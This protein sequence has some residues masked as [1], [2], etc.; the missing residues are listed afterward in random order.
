[1]HNKRYFQ[2]DIANVK[3]NE[4]KK[5]WQFCIGR[6]NAKLALQADYQKQLKQIV[7]ELGIKRVRFHGIFN[8]GLYVVRELQNIINV[9]RETPNIREISFQ[10]IG[11]VYDAIIECGAQPFVEIGMMP[12][13]YAS[14]DITLFQYKDNISMPKHMDEWNDL[15]QKFVTFLLNRY[16]LEEIRQWYFEVWNEPDIPNFFAGEMDDYF[17]LYANTAKTVKNIDSELKIG[18][19]ATSKSK[20]IKEFKDYC[21]TNEVPLDFISTHHY[22]GDALGHSFDKEKHIKKIKRI[23]D[24][25]Y[26]SLLDV[27]R[28]I[29]YNEDKIKDYPSNLL[30]DNAA[31]VS[32]IAEDIPVYYTEW[33][34]TSTTVATVNDTEYNAAYVVKTC[35]ETDS[36]IDGSSYWTFS[37]IFEE[38]A[39]FT[40]PFYGGFGLLT[41]DGI[42]KPNYYAFKFLN[43]LGEK[44]YTLVGNEDHLHI[45]LFKGESDLK[46]MITNQN[47]DFNSNDVIDYEI[48]LENCLSEV[49]E[50]KRINSTDSNSYYQWKELG[51]P[52]PLTKEQIK[53]IREKSKEA[54]YK[55]T[56]KNMDNKLLIEGTIKVNEV[57]VITIK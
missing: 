23:M 42:K 52:K 19:P 31:R 21:D 43:E 29:L 5:N 11:K 1:M 20:W 8:E 56:H 10:Q 54:I 18:G 30:K 28:E 6:G 45:S 22:P 41:I 32:K 12:R 47:F 36:I 40:D 39:Y 51:S 53:L 4:Y 9:Q 34:G 37:D 44:T 7:S 55:T 38:L 17:E 57:K 16:G 15:I 35:L 48:E 2:V 46:L 25:D 50:E 24:N 33:N 27:T 49:V 26:D 14:E 3:W 13:V